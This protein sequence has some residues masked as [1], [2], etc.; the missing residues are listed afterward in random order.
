MKDLGKAKKV[1]GMK[2]ERDRKSG[3]VSLRQKEYLKKVL[4]KF[5]NCDTKSVSIPLVLHFKLKAITSPTSIEE[6]EH[7]THVTYASAIGSLMY[8]MVCTWSD[9]SQVISTVNR[10]MHEPDRDHWEAVKWI[11]WYIK[12]TISTGL[13][14]KK[15]STSK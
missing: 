4:H 1:L 9:L 13:V 14:F 12:G 2:I 8:A 5:I 6:C 7:M 11:L 15:D 3:K 10:Y